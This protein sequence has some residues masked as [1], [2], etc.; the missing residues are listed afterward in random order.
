MRVGG[1]GGGCGW[2]DLVTELVLLRLKLV[3]YETVPETFWP[4]YQS[5]EK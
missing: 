5:G 3:Y 2:G 4:V 1:A